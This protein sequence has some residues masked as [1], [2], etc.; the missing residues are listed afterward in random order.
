MIILIH[1]VSRTTLEKITDI[2]HKIRIFE[3]HR[4]TFH[5]TINYTYNTKLIIRQLHHRICGIRKLYN[6]TPVKLYSLQTNFFSCLQVF[7]S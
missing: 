3:H 2:N 4:Y 5:G 6:R 1:L 7:L